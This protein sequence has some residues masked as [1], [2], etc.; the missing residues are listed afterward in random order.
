MTVIHHLTAGLAAETAPEVTPGTTPEVT[1]AP[2]PYAPAAASASPASPS[3]SIPA[4]SARPRPCVAITREGLELLCHLLLWRCDQELANNP[5][6]AAEE[7]PA[8]SAGLRR[9]AELITE[10]HLRRRLPM[11]QRLLHLWSQCRDLLSLSRAPQADLR[12]QL[13]LSLNTALCRSRVSAPHS[14]DS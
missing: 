7:R 6:I 8:L 14:L 13:R 10:W 2:L 1:P 12:H 3:P 5:G 4:S 9:Y 11:A